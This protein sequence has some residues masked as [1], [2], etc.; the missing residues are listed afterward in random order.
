[1]TWN[2]HLPLSYAAQYGHKALVKMLV[3]N[4]V[5]DNVKVDTKDKSG[6]LPLSHAARLRGHCDS[7]GGEASY[8]LQHSFVFNYV[9]YR[10]TPY[11]KQEGG[12]VRTWRF[13]CML[14]VAEASHWGLVPR[15]SMTLPWSNTTQ[16]LTPSQHEHIKLGQRIQ[17]TLQ[18]EGNEFGLISM[19]PSAD[20][21]LDLNIE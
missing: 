8:S 9:L 3:L 7:G 20:M 15:M 2:G 19:A 11:Q 6:H 14:K 12:D 17:Y 10:T 4:V 16:T 18:Y 13:A 5:Q 21:H 1:M